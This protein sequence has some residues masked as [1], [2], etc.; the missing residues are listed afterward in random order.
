MNLKE[1]GD[2]ALNQ[3][4]VANPP[5]NYKYLGECVSLIQQYL[6]RVFGIPFQAHGHAKDWAYNIPNGFTKV[7][8][9]PQKGDIVVYGANYPGS[10]GCGHILFIDY[11]GKA[12]EQNGAKYHAVSYRDTIPNG[13][14]A[15]LRPND[16]SKLGLNNTS[17]Q[18][19]TKKKL[20]LP[21]TVDR[22]RVYP[23]D[24]QPV[25]G[26]ECGFLLPS[27]FGG[28]DYEIIRWTQP[29]VVAV[30]KTRDYGEVQIYVGSDTS[31]VIS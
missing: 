16:Q 13:Y 26:N 2:W 1:F 7:N 15:I 8:S 5:P 30:I 29:N 9:N 18:V 27:K 14:I 12:F 21:S 28:L 11:N 6:Y 24:K 10:G 20:H 22:W 3:G 25:I 4:S 19:T 17:N 31:A 23:L